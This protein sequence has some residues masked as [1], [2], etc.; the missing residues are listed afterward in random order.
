MASPG[1]LCDLCRGINIESLLIPGG[2]RHALTLAVLLDQAPTCRLCRLFISDERGNLPESK[3][4]LLS[5]GPVI[6]YMADTDSR[7]P[8]GFTTMTVQIGQD[9]RAYRYFNLFTL[10]DDPATR[11]GVSVRG[12][13]STTASRHSFQTAQSWLLT[14]ITSHNCSNAVPFLVDRYNS[15]SWPSRLLDVK[16]FSNDV[17][18]V[19][20]KGPGM[21]YAALSYCWG[22][23]AALHTSYITTQRTLDA[24]RQRI[25][26]S[27]LPKTL[28]D[29]ITICR[30]LE[31][32]YLWI[33]ALCIIQDSPSDWQLEAIK[34]GPIY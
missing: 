24:N 6:C 3:Y 28:R 2:Y 19:D 20:V 29:A 4:G 16:S 5:D 10:Q 30:R 26:Y 11:V 13:L 1:Q 8:G 25:M 32:Q 7:A 17:R 14:C 18:L 22:G 27:S 33:D 31:I 12:H 9:N 15:G 21:P 34:M 23:N